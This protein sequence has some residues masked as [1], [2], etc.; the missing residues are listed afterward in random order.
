MIIIYLLLYCGCW[1]IDEQRKDRG[2]SFNYYYFLVAEELMNHERIAVNHLIIIIFWFYYFWVW[3]FGG[4]RN[5]KIMNYHKIIFIVR[6]LI[7]FFWFGG[8]AGWRSHFTHNYHKIYNFLICQKIWTPRRQT[9][10][11]ILMLLNILFLF[12]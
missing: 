4:W 3:R 10:T 1:R 2:E 11:A 8:L 7:S 12:F 6:N 9:A 5:K